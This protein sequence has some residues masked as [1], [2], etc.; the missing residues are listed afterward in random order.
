MLFI[1]WP[2]CAVSSYIAD[3]VSEIAVNS[4]WAASPLSVFFWQNVKSQCRCDY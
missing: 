4:Q 3:E 2:V 1:H